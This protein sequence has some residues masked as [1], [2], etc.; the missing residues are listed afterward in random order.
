MFQNCA[1]LVQLISKI[2]HPIQKELMDLCNT[3]FSLHHWIRTKD[4]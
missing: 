2:F 4:D 3:M 1:A